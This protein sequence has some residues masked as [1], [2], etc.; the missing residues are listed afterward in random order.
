MN[1]KTCGDCATF[2]IY[3]NYG[4][5]THNPKASAESFGCFKSKEE[6]KSMT[7]EEKQSM[8]VSEIVKIPVLFTVIYTDS[9]NTLQICPCYSEEKL[10]EVLTKVNKNDLD[11]V[12]IKG[13]PE[14]VDVSTETVLKF[15]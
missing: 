9:F 5:A 8:T 15:E 4:G 6:K 7:A 12:V 13:D 1:K 11:F 2:D 14:L 10:L 3:C